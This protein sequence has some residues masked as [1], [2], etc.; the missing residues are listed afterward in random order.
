MNFKNRLLNIL[1]WSIISAAFIGPGTITTAASAGAGFAYGLAWALVFST[2]A[3]VVLQEASARLT[4]ASG[5]NLGQAIANR[6]RNG[7]LVGR[8]L[9]YLVLIAILTGCAAYEAGNILGAVAGAGLLFNIGPGILAL[10]IG[11]AAFFLLWFNTPGGVA[12]ILGVIVAVMGICFL[13]TAL[14]SD[15]R[16]LQLLKGSLMPSTPSGSEI[17]VIGLIGTTVVPY[18]LFLGSGLRHAQ[19]LKEMRWSLSLAIVLGGIIS[20]AVLVVGNLVSGAFSY[21]GLAD[22]LA[23]SLGSWASYF[24]GFGLFAAGLSSAVTAPLAASITTKSILAS[25]S[26]ERWNDTGMFFR[27]VWMAVLLIGILFGVTDIQPIPAIILAQALNGIILPLVAALLFIMVN[28]INLLNRETVNSLWYNLLMGCIVFITIV[29]GLSNVAKALSRV[30]EW[31]GI[32]ETWILYLATGVAV[33][34]SWPVI[35]LIRQNREI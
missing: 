23:R 13:A 34:V 6:F 16:W 11:I 14:L 24:F 21:E 30:F 19:S 25:G 12:R 28:D 22:E 33:I 15:T 3:C 35:R 9:P 27:G 7:T 32:D 2:V 4:L 1:F 18:N 5:R 20:I 8:G 29:I 26:D 31:P 10:I 17:L